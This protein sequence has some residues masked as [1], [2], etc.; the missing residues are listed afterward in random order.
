L[1][2]NDEGHVYGFEKLTLPNLWTEIAKEKITFY[3]VK[4]LKD[5][6]YAKDG[7]L[8]MV[9]GFGVI[10]QG[11]NGQQTWYSIKNGLPVNFFSR[12]A[13]SPVGEVWI[14]GT[15]NALFRLNGEQWIDEGIKFPLPFDTREDWVCYSKDIV[16][17]DF[18]NNGNVWAMNAGI[19]IYAQA[20]DQWV[21][22]PFPKNMLPWAGGGACPQGI[23][24][25]SENN[26]TIK[27]SGC[28]D[29]GPAGY[30]FD[31]KSWSGSADFTVVDELFAVRHKP[32]PSLINNGQI[33][34]ISFTDWPVA[35]EIA[36]PDFSMGYRDGISVMADLNGTVWLTDGVDLYN[37]RS[38]KF[39]ALADNFAE[40]H[41]IAEDSNV[42]NFGNVILYHQEGKRPSSLFWTLRDMGIQPSDFLGPADEYSTIDNQGR[43]WIY[44]PQ[45][46]LTVI[47]KGIPRTLS[48]L[49]DLTYANRGGILPL[50]DGRVV[51]GSNGAIWVLDNGLWQKIAIPGQDQLFTYLRE[52]KQGN[53]YAAT[54]TGVYEIQRN[55]FT[56]VN[57]VRQDTKPYIVAKNIKDAGCPFRK[58]YIAGTTCLGE[59]NG[60]PTTHY[61]VKLLIVQEDN[62]VIYVNNKIIAKFENGE[63]K[64]FLFDTL[65]IESAAVD[66]DGFIWVYTGANGLI[67]FAP[68]IFDSYQNFG[69]Q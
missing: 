29:T 21:N 30:R 61:S 49:E 25:V 69:L 15:N 36:L 63:W 6:T 35:N 13:I 59:R 34:T 23:R 11:L 14:G 12:V 22:F 5:F 52:T 42:L 17:I 62:S 54:N 1:Q 58:R 48:N 2:N 33:K 19:E 10:H 28:C 32:D 68:D 43:I 45:K 16:G 27:R 41:S 39:E 8:W 51:V 9:G 31:G 60:I 66:K 67:R 47:E 46:G 38:G 7:S 40:N 57:F 24:V 56:S 65:D 26:I 18:D 20:Y 53:I 55:T 44:A 4:W 50:K 37:N 64:S 3:P